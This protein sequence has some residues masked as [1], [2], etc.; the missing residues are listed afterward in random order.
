M[1]FDCYGYA[2]QLSLARSIALVSE[3]EGFVLTQSSESLSTRQDFRVSQ[4]DWDFD[5]F[6]LI[7]YSQS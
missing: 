1:I 2:E 3:L 4:R 5:S 7:L 6:E